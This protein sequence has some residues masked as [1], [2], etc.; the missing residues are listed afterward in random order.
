MEDKIVYLVK[1]WIDATKEDDWFQCI[2]IDTETFEVV[3]K[4]E[5]VFELDIPDTNYVEQ[6]WENVLS[7][8]ELKGWRLQ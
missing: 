7:L 1:G 6:N 8:Y 4:E 5:L 3:D 2:G